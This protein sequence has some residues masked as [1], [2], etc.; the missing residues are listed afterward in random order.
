MIINRS[1]DIEKM[2][3]WPSLQGLLLSPASSDELQAAILWIIGTA[4][5]NNPTAQKA[6]SICACNTMIKKAHKCQYLSLPDS[7]LSKIL[8]RLSPAESSSGTRSKAVYALGGL[9]KHNSHSV[10]LLD[11]GE[12]WEVLRSALQGTF[13]CGLS[14]P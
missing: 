11:S 7:P 14:I 4:T 5:Q 10:S 13:V 9:L 2:G 3:M 8:A 6:V 12:G 1:T